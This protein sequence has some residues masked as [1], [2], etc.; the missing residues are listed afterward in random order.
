MEVKN[1]HKNLS[2]SIRS[3]K[4]TNEQSK[5]SNDIAKSKF[6]RNKIASPAKIVISKLVQNPDVHSKVLPQDV[7][8]KLRNNKEKALGILYRL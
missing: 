8:D 5:E 1:N 4:P 2:S 6:E 7:K 3:I